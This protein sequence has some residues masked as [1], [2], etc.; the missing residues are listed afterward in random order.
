M[1]HKSATA[2]SPIH[3]PIWWANPEKIDPCWTINSDAN[4]SPATRLRY[5]SLS[6]T[7]IF[8][9]TRYTCPPPASTP[10]P[11]GRVATTS[12]GVPRVGVDRRHCSTAGRPR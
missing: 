1:T 6:P 5:L 7:S 10:I 4:D 2:V 8:S 3:A 9:A 11:G 12:P